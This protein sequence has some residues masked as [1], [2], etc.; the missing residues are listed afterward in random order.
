MDIKCNGFFLY[1]SENVYVWKT[2]VWLFV[3]IYTGSLFYLILVTILHT[4]EYR[5]QNGILNSLILVLVPGQL[6]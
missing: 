5:I 1:E 3:I 6:T 2:N 4:V